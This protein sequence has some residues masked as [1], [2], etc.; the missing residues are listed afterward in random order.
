MYEKKLLSFTI[1]G[2]ASAA[3]PSTSTNNAST[4]AQPNPLTETFAQARDLL[5]EKRTEQEA[6]QRF[7]EGYNSDEDEYLDLPLIQEETLILEYKQALN[8]M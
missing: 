3:G 7:R 5:E 4:S 6:F 2:L 1:K 8:M